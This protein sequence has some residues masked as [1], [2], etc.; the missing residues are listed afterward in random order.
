MGTAKT[1]VTVHAKRYVSWQI[2]FQIAL[3]SAFIGPFVSSLQIWAYSLLCCRDTV[4]FSPGAE[5]VTFAKTAI[6][7][8][9]QVQFVRFIVEPH[10]SRIFFRITCPFTTWPSDMAVFEAPL[11]GERRFFMTLN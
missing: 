6:F 9:E 7:V 1:Y 2:F 10:I 3:D 5:K 11:Q 4:I 8:R